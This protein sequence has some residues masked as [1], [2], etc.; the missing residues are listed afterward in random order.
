MEVGLGPCHHCFSSFPT[1]QN[2]SNI[3]N[4]HLEF[5]S[6]TLS[7]LILMQSDRN[8]YSKF[9]TFKDCCLLDDYMSFW[10]IWFLIP[11]FAPG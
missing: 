9:G 5:A 8:Y 4:I 10:H 1:K 2:V 7:M 3:L 6:Y 11:A